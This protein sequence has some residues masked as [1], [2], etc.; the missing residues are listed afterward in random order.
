MTPEILDRNRLRT[1][2]SLSF[3]NSQRFIV[4][5]A[6]ILYEIANISL[7]LKFTLMLALNL[8]V[9]PCTATNLYSLSSIG[10]TSSRLQLVML[11][12]EC[13]LGQKTHFENQI[14]PDEEVLP[15]C[16]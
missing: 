3:A 14:L 9:F 11:A 2:R 12:R 16:N 8:E 10:I 13:S 15:F 7:S 4:F 6:V 5:N 1:I